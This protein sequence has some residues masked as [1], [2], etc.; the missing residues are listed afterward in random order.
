MPPSLEE[1]K[2]Q[3]SEVDGNDSVIDI[4]VET[5]AC[6][7]M[8]LRFVVAELAA[9]AFV[10]AKQVGALVEPSAVADVAEIAAAE[11]HP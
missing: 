7:K 6:I 4:S 9:A 11:L 1:E 10:A 3:H 5:R 8:N 2:A